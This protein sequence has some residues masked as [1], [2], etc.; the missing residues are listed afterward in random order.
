MHYVLSDSIIFTLIQIVFEYL[1]YFLFYLKTEPNKPC[2]KAKEL[3]RERKLKKLLNKGITAEEA[4]S[5]MQVRDCILNYCNYLS[6]L[7]FFMIQGSFLK[8]DVFVM[9]LTFNYF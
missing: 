7:M 1:I 3:R 9:M 4:V 6:I 5:S 2:R 8:M